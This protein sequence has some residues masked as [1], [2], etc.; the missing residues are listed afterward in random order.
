MKTTRRRYECKQ[1]QTG[2]DFCTLKI[3]GKNTIKAT[4]LQEKR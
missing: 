1:M 4:S 3:E 2:D